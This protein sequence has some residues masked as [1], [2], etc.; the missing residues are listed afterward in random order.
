MNSNT[1]HAHFNSLLMWRKKEQKDEVIWCF[2][3]QCSVHVAC[4]S[5]GLKSWLFFMAAQHKVAH[6]KADSTTTTRPEKV[7]GSKAVR[8]EYW[9]RERPKHLW[10]TKK[11]QKTTFSCYWQKEIGA[12]LG[13]RM[14]SNLGDP[15]V[16]SGL[17]ASSSALSDKA[18]K[19]LPSAGEDWEVEVFGVGTLWRG[20]EQERCHCPMEP[21]GRCTVGSSTKKSTSVH[22]RLSVYHHPSSPW[23][24]FCKEGVMT[25]SVICICKYTLC[26]QQCLALCTI[27]LPHRGQLAIR[28][29][30][31]QA[32]EGL[33]SFPY[34]I[35]LACLSSMTT[36]GH[37]WGPQ[38][39]LAETKALGLLSPAPL[40][41][42]QL[43]VAL[44]TAAA[45]WCTRTA[46][47]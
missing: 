32:G 39:K 13:K 25:D 18:S 15:G 26:H 20:T 7:K 29:T 3:W 8:W 30:S 41:A 44:V 5:L 6:H 47:Y 2:P 23:L 1:T 12:P 24:F 46:C 22:Q 43:L 34:Q 42:A 4:P 10:H 19:V 38:D 16:A 28:V 36:Q 14:S 45:C 40:L 21:A 37:W 27:L 35:R 9:D 33:G 17:T 31:P 11:R